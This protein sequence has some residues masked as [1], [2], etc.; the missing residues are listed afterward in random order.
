[1][2]KKQTGRSPSLT[3][4]VLKGTGIAVVWTVLCAMM[5]A[6]LI[7]SEVMPMESVGYCS[8]AVHLSAVYLGAL[9]GKRKAAHMG[10]AAAGITGGCYYVILLMVNTLFFGGQFDGLG[11]TLALVVL[12]SGMVILTAGKGRSGKHRGRYK[13]PRA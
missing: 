10:D 8:M 2:M 1:M 12:S 6:Q 13:I 9:A 7:N 3:N 4:A 5:I 11:V